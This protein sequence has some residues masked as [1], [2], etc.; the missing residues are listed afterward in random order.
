MLRIWGMSEAKRTLSSF[1]K[2]RPELPETYREIYAEHYRRNRDGLSPASSL[3]QKIEAWM[4]RRVASDIATRKTPSRTLEIGAGNLNHVQYEPG[5]EIYDVVEDLIEVLEMSP[6]RRLIR[7]AYRSV[8]EILNEK[9]D[10]IV[11]IAAFEHFCDLPT[12]VAKCALLLASSGQLRIGI[13]SEGTILWRLGWRLTTGVEFRARH[14]LNYGVLMR[15]E[16]VNTAKEIEDILRFFFKNVRREVLGLM[17]A[18]SFY[19]YF[20]CS[21]PDIQRCH[22]IFDRT[23]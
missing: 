10:R 1:P 21:E 11:S 19:Q 3:S 23:R 18:L 16:H 2:V 17:P 12:A 7:H 20:E 13:P 4:H 15:H 8:D 9:Y 14:G 5:S 6:R 22:G